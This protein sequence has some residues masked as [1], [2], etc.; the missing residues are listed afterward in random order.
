MALMVV[1]TCPCT[2]TKPMPTPTQ[3][4][5]LIGWAVLAGVAFLTFWFLL[6]VVFILFG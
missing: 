2:E 1:N 3:I 4:I 5:R 6:V